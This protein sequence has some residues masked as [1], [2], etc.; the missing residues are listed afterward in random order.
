MKHGHRFLAI[1]PTFELQ[2][3][4]VEPAAAVAMAEFVGVV[5]LK[6]IMAHAAIS[7]G[8]DLRVRCGFV[9]VGSGAALPGHPERQRAVAGSSLLLPEIFL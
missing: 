9:G 4:L 2:T 6:G 1:P 5:V 8:M 7:P 3:L